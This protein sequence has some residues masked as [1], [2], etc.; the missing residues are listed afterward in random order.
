MLTTWQ[1]SEDPAPAAMANA[2]T[3]A[4]ASAFIAKPPAPFLESPDSNKDG[5]NVWLAAWDNYLV[6]LESVSRGA[7][8]DAVKNAMLLNAIGAE[9][10]H[11]SMSD[12]VLSKASEKT[13]TVFKEAATRLFSV[14]G[15]EVRA[16]RDLLSRRQLSDESVG[17]YLSELRTLAKL[18]S[19]S[20]FVH[21]E[22]TAE[23][24]ILAAMLALGVNSHTIQQR[25]LREA[26]ISLKEFINLASAT[27]AAETDHNKIHGARSKIHA[28]DVRTLRTKVEPRS[29]ESQGTA[30]NRIHPSKDICFRCGRS[31]RHDDST[32][33]PAINSKCKKCG[34]VGHFARIC[35]SSKSKPISIRSATVKVSTVRNWTFDLQFI[36][37]SGRIC[38]IPT[39]LDT[40]ADVTLIASS[41]YDAKLSHFSL[42]DA[43]V[44]FNF[45]GSPIEGIRGVFQ[46]PVTH[47][48]R[49][50]NISIYV[51][52]DHMESTTG[53]DAIQQ[54]H[55]VL[56]GATQSVRTV[57]QHSAPD[58]LSQFPSLVSDRI[59]TY[60]D[61]EHTLQLRVGAR[62]RSQKVCLIPLA[63]RDLVHV[64]VQRMV[65]QGIWEP[66]D[67][68]DWA[69]N[70]VPIMKHDGGIRI[71]T[72]FT[73]L[74][75]QIIPT[76][77]PLPN[78]RDVRVMLSGARYFSKLDLAKA[79]YHVILAAESRPLTATCT[80]WG[81][82]Q[83]RRLPMGLKDSAA[84][85]Q[86]CVERALAGVSGCIVYIDDIL[87]FA[88]SAAEHDSVLLKVLER[89]HH[90]DFRLNLT[91][92]EFK[93]SRVRFLGNV[94]SSGCIAIDSECLQGIRDMPTPT[95]PKQLQSFLGMVN[96]CKDFFKDAA[97]IVEPLQRLLRKGEPWFWGPNQETAL[98]TIR[99]RLH[100]IPEL[101]SFEPAQPTIVTTD[102]SGDGLG[103][104]LQQIQFGKLVPIAYASRTLSP[105]ERNY[106]TNEREA[107]GVLWALE[108]W[109]SYLLGRRFTLCCD[110]KPLQSL[111]QHSSLRKRDK[112]IRWSERLSRFDFDFEFVTGASNCLADCLSRLPSPTVTHHDDAIQSNSVTIAKVTDGINMLTILH[113]A[114]IDNQYAALLQA[115]HENSWT[116]VDAPAYYSVRETL[117]TKVERGIRYAVKDDR[118]VVPRALRQLIL[119]LAHRGHPG[120]VHM[121]QKLR[122][123]YWWPA[124]DA[125]AEHYVRHCNGCQASSKS[126]D[127][128]TTMASESVPIPSVAWTKL[129]L[130]I[131]GPFVVAPS[132]QRYI[133]AAID[134]TSKFAAIHSC[135]D[136]T[137]PSIMQWLDN[138][139]SEFGLPQQIVTDNG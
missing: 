77:H 3:P 30:H 27:E 104:T 74:N 79:Y 128:V 69:H 4:A 129:A 135:A 34:K 80:P 29:T 54:L 94:I 17:S 59:G 78:I 130:D 114:R 115:I 85:F 73:F 138:L 100:N 56:E 117:D 18:T 25:L 48:G 133:V 43:P 5:W 124:M 24:Y 99:T 101:H 127:K 22:N 12:P 136:I 67:K 137:S 45:D 6:V 83:Y 46:A 111:L 10:F 31:G 32:K 132:M 121:K 66:C 47:A 116:N 16:I 65:E 81:V 8:S 119:R 55:M 63:K 40:G 126:A 21:G 110:H 60:P 103:A 20:Q 108:H 113:A 97:T 13:Y 72:D 76:R 70:L 26:T 33:C 84:V 68:S 19:L 52:P 28:V 102:A 91:K 38:S 53:R 14:K 35:Q 15:S 64:E 23:E 134:Y 87:V 57:A 58:F 1:M 50:A 125:E 9:G 89:L 93:T 61:F 37:P 96:Y 105:A 7:I 118:I 11:L 51:V 39:K 36:L 120:I 90:H 75:P 82:F 122:S 98:D 95:S 131:T 42:S 109:E 86:Q 2:L 49:T 41:E 139:F 71:T 123:I 107:L 92:C 88:S 112:F 62:P 44:L 106:A